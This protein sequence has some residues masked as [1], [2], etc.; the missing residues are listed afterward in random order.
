MNI[1]NTKNNFAKPVDKNQPGHTVLRVG[2]RTARWTR[3]I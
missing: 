2:K 3:Q 1:I